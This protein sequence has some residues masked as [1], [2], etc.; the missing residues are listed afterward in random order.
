MRAQHCERRCHV[1]HPA[2]WAPPHQSEADPASVK[3]FI[4]PPTWS[5]GEVTFHAIG[6]DHNQLVD[7]FTDNKISPF[8]QIIASYL[9]GFLD[10][11]TRILAPEEARRR[12]AAGAGGHEVAMAP[13]M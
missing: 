8:R 11:E 9:S 12:L 2:L 10:Q 6:G 7:D 4:T 5:R 13:R 1:S 3:I